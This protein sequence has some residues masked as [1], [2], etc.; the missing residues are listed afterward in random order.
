MGNKKGEYTKNY[1]KQDLSKAYKV[2][3]VGWYQKHPNVVLDESNM[4]TY[5]KEYV[6]TQQLI[7]QTLKFSPGKFVDSSLETEYQTFKSNVEKKIKEMDL[8]V[9]FNGSTNTIDIGQS[10]TLQDKNKVLKSYP[11]FDVTDSGIRFEH[12]KGSNDLK[13]T[14]TN[15]CKVESYQLTDQKAKKLGIQLKYGGND[16]GAFIFDDGD[17]TVMYTNGY[18][19][20][21][22][23]F[24]NINVNLY[25]NLE[26]AKKDDKGNFIANTKFK[27]S[28][29]S[30]M[31]NIIGI[32]TTGENGKVVINDLNPKVIYIQEVEVPDNLI[33]DTEVHSIVVKPNDTTTYTATNSWK[34]GRIKAIKKDKETGKVVKKDGTVFDIYNSSNNKVSSMTTNVEGIAT[35][36]LLDYGIYYIKESKAPNSYTI[37]AEVSENIN[38]NENG[39]IY[40]IIVTNTR[41]KGK[42]IISKEDS[43]TGKKVQGEGSL[44]GAVYGIYARNPILDPADGSAIYNQDEKI[45][46]VI[47]DKDANASMNELYL[48]EY[49]VKEIKPSLGYNLDTTEYD[50]SLDYEG[51][52]VTIVTKNVE[53]KERVISQ[54]FQII[55]V[56]VEGSTEAQLLKGAEFTIKAQKDIEKFGSWE[57]APVAKNANGEETTILTTDEKGYAISERLPYRNVYCA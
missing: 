45:G 4:E 57:E 47:T 56:S 39:K 13:I 41:V 6:F 16:F 30:D 19:S 42:V 43:K 7:W 14:I 26:I 3:Y 50:F 28:Y 36:E 55:K 48:G 31:S 21:P 44:Q 52:E 49:Y 24:L 53:V 15:E 40:E 33:L 25:G 38:I 2:A 27:I 37:K 18:T 1:A 35:S 29:N 10:K 9:S 12:T 5:K 11:T 8:R 17:Q 22:T 23:L 34:Q 51:Q 32:Y 20:D 46:E 54:P